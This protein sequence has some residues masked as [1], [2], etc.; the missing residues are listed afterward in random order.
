MRTLRWL[1]SL[2]TFVTVRKCEIGLRKDKQD[3]KSIMTTLCVSK[4]ILLYYHLS[5]CILC[6]YIIDTLIN[7]ETQIGSVSCK[8]FPTS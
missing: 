6:F 5:L 7:L 1:K 2:I 4:Y 8:L 3:K